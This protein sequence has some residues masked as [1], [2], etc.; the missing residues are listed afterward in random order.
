MSDLGR[1]LLAGVC[2]NPDDDAPR[3]VYA[4]WLVEQG[5]GVRAEAIRLGVRRRQMD[6]LDPEAWI[7]DEQRKR[8]VEPHLDAWRKGL[9]R[10]GEWR[11]PR[12]GLAHAISLLN[13]R[14]I[15]EHQDAIFAAG[16]VTHL[17][18]F[19]ERGADASP[20]AACRYAGRLRTLELHGVAP[21][22]AFSLEILAACPALAKVRSLDLS[23]NAHSDRILESLARCPA[24]PSLGRLNLYRGLYGPPGIRALANAPIVRSL[25]S[26]SLAR[27]HN[28]QAAGVRELLRSGQLTE[29]RELNLSECRIGSRVIRDLAEHPWQ[30]LER[31]DLSS[32]DLTVA[33]IRHLAGSARMASVRSLMLSGNHHVKD[34]G[35]VALARSH[36]LGSLVD[37]DLGWWKLGPRGV[38]ALLDAPWMRQIRRLH[39]CSLAPAAVAILAQ[40]ELPSLRWLD[41]CYSHLT[42]EGLGRLLAA[43][44][45]PRLT[46]LDLGNNA[47]TAAGAR[48]L[49]AAPGLDGVVSLDVTCNQIDDEGKELLRRR[50][51][52]RVSVKA[53]WE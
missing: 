39:L 46:F 31:L 11:V 12:E 13:A 20:I 1:Q 32:N 9:P 4:D 6:D 8:L 47:L 28:V 49:A 18:T 3:L 21:A 34:D 7:L 36:H 23:E 19:V 50:F 45:L 26:L 35:A 37:L 25:R 2:E 17:E 24:W 48:L 40:A 38:R 15:T 44:W 52:E 14:A 27:C 22:E 30:R 42:D 41:L 29:L 43:S 10:V 51:G 16:P 53:S 5:D 33:G